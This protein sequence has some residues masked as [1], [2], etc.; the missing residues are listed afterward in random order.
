MFGR[1]SKVIRLFFVGEFLIT[2]SKSLLVIT[3][4]FRFSV[5]SYL[6]SI[7]YIFLRGFIQVIQIIHMQFIV[8]S[9]NAFYFYK[10]G[11]NISSFIS[12]FSCLSHLSL[13]VQLKKSSILLIFSKNLLFFFGFIYFFSCLVDLFFNLYFQIGLFYC[14]KLYLHKI[15][16]K[17]KNNNHIIIQ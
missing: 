7:D 12:D 9:Y 4:L 2:D 3:G 13:T 17:I 8:L 14:M 5:P 15:Y 6:V 1:S 16:F 10:K 11:S